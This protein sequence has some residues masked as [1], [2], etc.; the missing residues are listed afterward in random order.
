MTT[1]DNYPALT[2]LYQAWQTSNSILCCGLDPELD[3]LPE[4]IKSGPQPLLNFCKEIVD[5]TAELVCAFKL[6]IAFFSAC[7]AEEEAVALIEYIRQKAPHV[8]VILDAKR[9][10]IGNTAKMYAEEAFLRYKADAVT[11]NPYMGRDSVDPFTG[12]A[13]KGVIVLCRTSNTGSGEFQ[14]TKSE[15][16][17]PLFMQVAQ[18]AAGPWNINRN[19]CLVMGATYPEELKA[20]R[21]ACPDVPFLIPGVGAQGGKLEDVI[22]VGKSSDGWGMMINASRSILYASSGANFGEAARREA[23]LLNSQMNDLRLQR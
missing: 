6:Q 7:G 21:Q 15:H 10:D 14:L 19:I 17:E 2:R 4:V 16:G 22:K 11:V 18:H 8:Y 1:T 20:V 9:G 12:Y 13:D 3:K 23:H 5:H